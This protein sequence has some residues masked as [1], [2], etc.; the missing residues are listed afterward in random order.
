[1]APL[2]WRV[3]AIAGFVAGFLVG[4]PAGEAYRSREDRDDNTER[5]LAWRGRAD[6]SRPSTREGMT[7]EER[8]RIVIGA[9]LAI[10]G[11]LALFTYFATS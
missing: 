11:A 2:L 3:L 4:W 9:A 1:M 5:Y 6:R 8:R 7:A 10:A